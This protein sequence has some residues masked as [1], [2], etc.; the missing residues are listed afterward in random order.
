VNH[1]YCL[2]PLCSSKIY[3]LEYVD[4]WDYLHSLAIKDTAAVFGFELLYRNMFSS[5]LGIARTCPA[6]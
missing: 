2:I 6:V 5:Y 4:I 3:L 1:H